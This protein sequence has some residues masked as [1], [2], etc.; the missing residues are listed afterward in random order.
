MW[1]KG[2]LTPAILSHAP[3]A[4]AIAVDQF[5]DR[6]RDQW[7][8]D[9]DEARAFVTLRLNAAAETTAVARVVIAMRA[10]ALR[11]CADGRDAA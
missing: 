1:C 6:F 3:C 8:T 9:A 5:E 4:S 7:M 11:S 2:K 10:D